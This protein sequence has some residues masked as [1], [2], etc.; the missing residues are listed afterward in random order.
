MQKGK[1][2][3]SGYVGQQARVE[4]VKKIPLRHDYSH[5]DGINYG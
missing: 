2:A 5:K 1:N 3:M 4:L